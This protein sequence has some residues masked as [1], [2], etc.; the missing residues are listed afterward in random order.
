MQVKTKNMPCFGHAIDAVPTRGLLFQKGPEKSGIAAET[1]GNCLVYYSKDLNVRAK[2]TVAIGKRVVLHFPGF[3]KMTTAGHHGRFL[4]TAE[5]TASLWGFSA[6]IGPLAADVS[7]AGFTVVAGADT[8]Q[9]TSRIHICD[10][11]TLVDELATRPLAKR[12][13]TGFRSAAQV[14]VEGGLAGYFRHGW[15]F[16]LFFLFP[17]LLMLSGI[18]ISLGLA[19]LPQW[20]SLAHWH[21]L[22]S[23]PLAAAFFGYGVLPFAER[24]YTLHLFSDWEMAVA[25]ANGRSSSVERFLE[26]RVE[27]LRR[28]LEEEADEYVISSHSMGSSLAVQVLGM[29][30]ERYPQ[31]LA[32]K[33]VVFVT[34][35][36]AILQC[37]LLRSAKDLRRRVGLIARTPDVTWLEVQCLTDPINFYKSRVVAVT[38]HPSAPQAALVTIRVKHLLSPERY[39]RI[40]RD[41]LRVHRQYVLN[42]DRKGSFDFTLLTSGPFPAALTTD[43]AARSFQDLVPALN[44]AENASAPDAP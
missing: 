14:V 27:T 7:G 5:H 39:A 16:A 41:F 13:L 11:D 20:L 34:L 31:A 42:A 23:L 38:G 37:A 24:F 40:R 26:D 22:W 1:G 15:R 17:F 43:Y 44:A 12:L 21:S 28:A 9:T 25:V 33:R 3:E 18:G 6:D 19:A 2:M 8:W 10:H 4:R 30:L 32:G 35:G 36:G 29:L